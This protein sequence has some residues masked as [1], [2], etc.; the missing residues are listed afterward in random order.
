MTFSGVSAAHQDT[1]GAL[2]KTA[3]YDVGMYHAGAHDPDYAGVGGILHPEDARQVRPGVRA[4]VAQESEDQRFELFA[5][6]SFRSFY[7]KS[8]PGRHPPAPP[9]VPQ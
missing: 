7:S 8:A 9:P 4:P 6:L 2:G 3:D 1:V 5:H